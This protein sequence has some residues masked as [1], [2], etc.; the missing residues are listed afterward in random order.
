MFRV[1]AKIKGNI[2]I[3]LQS[4]FCFLILV[5]SD[6]GTPRTGLCKKVKSCYPNFKLFDF[7][8]EDTWVMGLYDTCSYQ[9]ALGRQVQDNQY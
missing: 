2:R 1:S 7:S 9:S 3:L 4:T 5:S 6:K 8:S